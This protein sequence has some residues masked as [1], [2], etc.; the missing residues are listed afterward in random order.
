[1]HKHKLSAVLFDLDGLLVD[2]YDAW[3]HLLNAAAIRWG[4]PGIDEEKY[5]RVFG[6]SVEAD[7]DILFPGLEAEKL[8]L[9]FRERFFDYIG[10]FREIPGARE[11]FAAVR[12]L[13]LSTA[14]VT[15]TVTPLARRILDHVGFAPDHVVGSGDV[16]RDKPHPD[17]VLRALDLLGVTATAAVMV[18]DSD[19]DR[20]AATGAGVRFIG[21][22][23]TGDY[24]IAD[25]SQL[26][27]LLSTEFF[28]N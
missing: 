26:A 19:F 18:G 8:S 16:A 10:D 24:S 13:G 2:S 20:R 11:M 14:V 3:F 27:P 17:M 7:V 21:F 28:I 5:K 1:M 9:F 6:Q 23:R 4:Y 25:L 22:K 12:A 15:N